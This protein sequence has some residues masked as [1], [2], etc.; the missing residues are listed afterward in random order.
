MYFLE[1]SYTENEDEDAAVDN[2]DD[3]ESSEDSGDE[4]DGDDDDSGDDDDDVD[5]DDMYDTDNKA[6][7]DA[8]HLGFSYHT[9]LS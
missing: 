5:D 3:D 2:G 7:D 4:K 1:K 6:G 9:H 8:I